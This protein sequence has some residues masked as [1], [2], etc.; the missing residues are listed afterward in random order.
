[1][2]P[3]TL[4]GTKLGIQENLKPHL[5]QN[6]TK[7]GPPIW[8]DPTIFT[9]QI[10]QYFAIPHFGAQM[11]ID[12]SF[13]RKGGFGNLGQET[14]AQASIKMTN[15]ARPGEE[16]TIDFQRER[17]GFRTEAVT[18]RHNDGTTEKYIFSDNISDN[19]RHPQ[20]IIKGT[21][22]N[23]PEDFDISRTDG[24]III[25]PNRAIGKIVREESRPKSTFIPIKPLIQQGARLY[26]LEHKLAPFE[27]PPRDL[28]LDHP[29]LSIREVVLTQFLKL[30]RNEKVET[31]VLN[32]ENN[33]LT[34]IV[35]KIASIIRGRI[36][37]LATQ[38]K[39]E[40][41][42]KPKVT[43]AVNRLLHRAHEIARV[44][45][46]IIGFQTAPENATVT[47][48]IL[49]FF[50]S[51]PKTLLQVYSETEEASRKESKTVPAPLLKEYEQLLAQ[52]GFD[53]RDL[54]IQATTIKLVV[55]GID[56]LKERN[57]KLLSYADFRNLMEEPIVL[58]ITQQWQD[59][60]GKTIVIQTE[61]SVKDIISFL[62]DGDKQ[63]TIPKTHIK[64]G[65][66]PSNGEHI[67][68]K[69]PRFNIDAAPIQIDLP[70]KSQ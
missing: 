8:E 54:Q 6:S 2:G 53:E 33:T 30:L 35:S 42:K 70:A 17:Q 46:T 12:Y 56:Y 64:V 63:I 4:T 51:I 41:D 68:I 15:P 28:V 7:K 62:M 11:E 24:F 67:S 49:R 37:Q 22:D 34:S 52:L 5:T 40:K 48:F 23:F 55:N 31:E 47:T 39:A 19:K 36:N 20:L 3:L 60:G 18:I 16:L 21:K 13:Q 38:S 32:P 10:T 59:H 50:E 65:I 14:L 44:R 9:P 29:N 27:I 58:A 26:I 69:D 43:T 1:M 61:L 25:T 45:K 57:P 66:Y